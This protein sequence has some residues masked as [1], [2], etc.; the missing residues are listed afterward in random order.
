MAIEMIGSVYCPLSPRDPE[1]RL[2]SLVEQTQTQLVLVHYLTQRKFNQT[3]VTFDIDLILTN[4]GD[5]DNDLHDSVSKVTVNK[6]DIAYIIFTSGS[7]GIPKAV[8]AFQYTSSLQ[9]NAISFIQV[10]IR[11]RNFGA[12]MNA[13]NFVDS[14]NGNHTVVQMGRCSFDGHISDIMGA[15]MA[16]ASL[17]MLHPRGNIDFEY[18]SHVLKNRQISFIDAVPSVLEAFFIFLRDNDLYE[19]TK[20]LRTVCSGG[21]S[22]QKELIVAY[23]DVFISQVNHVL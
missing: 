22:I 10:K 20:C 3:I 6:D 13:A 23:S 9:S 19:A 17:I 7:T 5:I 2:H 12:R 18:L 21:K 11:H 16:G 14:F 1:H 8:C 4:K 15:L